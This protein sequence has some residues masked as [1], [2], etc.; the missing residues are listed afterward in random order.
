V[1]VTI[2][3][4]VFNQSEYLRQS[5]ESALA[6]D[7]TDI[8]PNDSVTLEVIVV[9]DKSTDNSLQVA[10]ECKERERQREIAEFEAETAAQAV[11]L[12]GPDGKSVLP[13]YWVDIK[14]HQLEQRKIGDLK[15]RKSPDSFDVYPAFGS[16]IKIIEQ[17]Q[18]MGL[19][20]ARNTGI[21]AASSKMGYDL[22]LPLD[23]D[24]WIEPNYLKKTVPLIKDKVGVVGTYAAV[25][26]IK[27]Y[28]W[29]TK[30]PAI[31]QLMEDNCVSVCSLIRRGA[32]EETKNYYNI[33][34]NSGYEDWNLWIDIRKRGWKIALVPE[35]LFHYREKPNSMLKDSTKIRPQL[36][37]KIHSLHPDLW[38]PDGTSRL[39]K[40]N[41]NPT[42][43]ASEPMPD[44]N[45]MLNKWAGIRDETGASALGLYGI[46]ATYEKAA[47]FLGGLQVEDWGCGK[48]YARK[49]FGSSYKG[50]DGTPDG[51]DVVVDL[52]KYTSQTQGI[53]LRHVLEHNFEWEKVLKN[54]LTSAQKLAIVVCTEFSDTT[55][56]LYIDDWG[57]PIFSFREEDLTCHFSSYTKEIVIGEGQGQQCS[58]T[59][60][61]VRTK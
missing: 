55:H 48:A 3:I 35:P 51:C 11:K 15:I 4:P 16:R 2:V 1:L 45:S 44:E 49:F 37:A 8:L 20:I 12:R 56:L 57:I 23:A 60:F 30:S 6:Q 27:D 7:V 5:I 61:Y 58:E 33:Q 53:L 29:T 46:E 18:N 43:I 21:N 24:D 25:F 22:I 47:K 59:I 14:R 42:H 28:I 17:P 41:A 9:D 10:R 31:E 50:V 19:V 40:P 36:V 32:M 54:A 34:L 39:V 13:T 52:T 38:A 26:G